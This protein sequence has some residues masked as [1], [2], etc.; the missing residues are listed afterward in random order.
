MARP[1]PGVPLGR[2]QGIRNLVVEQLTAAGSFFHCPRIHQ[3]D[4]GGP[5]DDRVSGKLVVVDQIGDAFLS[6]TGGDTG[7]ARQNLTHR[8]GRGAKDTAHN[9]IAI[10]GDLWFPLQAHRLAVELRVTQP[11]K[12]DGHSPSPH[13]IQT[14]SASNL[15][16][17]YP[18]VRTDPRD[19]SHRD[20]EQRRPLVGAF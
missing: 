13:T 3:S 1:T 7:D 6:P 8:D 11:R 16:G 17:D 20:P 9:Q 19:P 14:F 4:G 10:G 2:K 15:L 18:N 12:W 5:V